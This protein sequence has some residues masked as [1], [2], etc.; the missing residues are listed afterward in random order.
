MEHYYLVKALFSQ[1]L[2]ETGRCITIA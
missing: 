1:C 2:G